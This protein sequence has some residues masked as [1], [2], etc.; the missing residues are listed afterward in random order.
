M[1]AVFIAI[2]AAVAAFGTVTT[3]ST[4]DGWYA[5]AVKVA[6]S[7]PNWLFGPVWS[8]LYLAMAVSAWL[9]WRRRHVYFVGPALTLYVGQLFLNS[10]WTPVFFGGFTIIGPPALWIGVAVIV[11]LDICVAATIV[12]FWAVRPTAAYL[13]LP[14]LVWILYATT[15]NIGLAVL[16]T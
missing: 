10:V 2:S 14:Y 11:L 5:D 3:I 4:V 16:N 6:W 1:L 12:S 15:L 9:V 8:V 7:P 13:L